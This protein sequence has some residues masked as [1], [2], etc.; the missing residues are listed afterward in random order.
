ML[1]R[2]IEVALSRKGVS[3]PSTRKKSIR[4]GHRST[5]H[6]WWARR[7]LA[8]CRPAVFASPS[9]PTRLP[10]YLS[11][12]SGSE[13]RCGADAQRMDQSPAVRQGLLA[14]HRG[15]LPVEP[16][17]AHDPRFGSEARFQGTGQ[18]GTIHG[19]PNGLETGCFGIGGMSNGKQPK[20]QG[21]RHQDKTRPIRRVS[22]SV[23]LTK[24]V[25]RPS[26]D[27]NGKKT[28]PRSK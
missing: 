9:T 22:G 5:L 8:A 23:T 1:E 27:G 16:R 7:P 14:V 19:G 24:I 21:G 26:Y 13:R 28:G 15:Q 4:H 17:T 6:I 12:Q 10:V 11:E 25:R 20:E 2:V 18:R 3:E